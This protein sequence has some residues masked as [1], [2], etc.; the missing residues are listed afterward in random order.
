[1]KSWRRLVRWVDARL[2]FCRMPRPAVGATDPSDDSSEYREPSTTGRQRSVSASSPSQARRAASSPEDAQGRGYDEQEAQTQFSRRGTSYVD[3]VIGL[4]FG[5]LSS[6]AVVRSPFLGGGRA[7]PV[8]WRGRRGE[9]SHFLPAALHE[10]ANGAFTIPSDWGSLGRRNLKTGLMDRPDDLERRAQAAA[11]LGLT[12]RE[13]RRYVLETQAEVYGAYRLRWAVHVGIPSAGYDDVVVKTAFLSV[14][15]AAW[16]LSRR[17]ESPTLKTAAAALEMAEEAVDADLDVT[18]VRVFPEIAALVAG[19]A[20]SRRR[21]DGLHVMV[22]VG[23]TTIDV[24]GFGLRDR[25]G[26]DQ[27][28]LYTAVVA[29]VGIRE[30]HL[31]RVSAIRDADARHSLLVPESLDPFSEVPLAGRDYVSAPAAPLRSELDGL[32][33]RYMRLWTTELMSVLMELRKKRARKAAA[34]NTGVPL[35]RAGGGARHGLIAQAV[36]EAHYRLTTAT[37][38][39]GIDEQPLPRLEL[40]L[41]DSG[42]GRNGGSS[43]GDLGGPDILAARLGVACGLSFDE[44]KIGEIVPPHEIEDE[45]PM[46]KRPPSECPPP[47]TSW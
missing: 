35:F 28:L 24:C 46:P 29:P 38:T 39:R 12:L 6:R 16:L 3:L 42:S 19:Y 36:Q 13:A 5:T 10:G 14:A 9:A 40:E 20:R 11:Y 8:L 26:D 7:V 25:D 30:L 31:Q 1:M 27:Y 34:W 17:S 37:R 43:G 18:T 45:P 21:R 4:D 44:L 32:D 41:N 33:E 23:A 22:D 2:A 15:R 47:W